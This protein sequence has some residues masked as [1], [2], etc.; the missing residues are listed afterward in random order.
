MGRHKRTTREVLETLPLPNG[1]TECVARVLGATGGNLHRVQMTAR[2]AQQ[3]QATVIIAPAE[4]SATVPSSTAPSL[5]SS[6]ADPEALQ[7]T[8]F[9]ETLCQLP[10]R[11]RNIVFIKRGS[12]VIVDL[13]TRTGT[14]IGGEIIHVLYDSQIHHIKKH[15][16]WP[17]E[18]DLPITATHQDWQKAQQPNAAANP[19]STASL[20]QASL[21]CI[22]DESAEDSDDDPLLRNPN[23]PA[24]SGASDS[25]D[26]SE[27]E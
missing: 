13:S 27:S 22:S 3:I 5:Q 7:A 19:R 23:R 2:D 18:L 26:G 16:L 9:H 1:T 12:Y 24:Y 11:F 17:T 15:K 14:K 10:T 8:L 20:D 25:N 21:D 4:G 6:H